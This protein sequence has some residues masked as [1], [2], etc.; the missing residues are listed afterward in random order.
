[1]SLGEAGTEDQTVGVRPLI[2]AQMQLVRLAFRNINKS[3]LCCML[4]RMHLRESAL[5]RIALIAVLCLLPQLAIGGLFY[6]VNKL[7]SGLGSAQE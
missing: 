4:A 2:H 6:D 5:N 3:R 7:Y 1:M